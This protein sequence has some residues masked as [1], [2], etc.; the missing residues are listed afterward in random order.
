MAHF[1]T[2]ARPRK[3]PLQARSR[4]LVN[5]LMQATA[6]ILVRDGW[7]ALTTNRVANEAGVSVGSLYQYF[8]HKDALV[9]ALVESWAETLTAQ[10]VALGAELLDAS[11]EVGARRLVETVLDVTRADQ[12]LHRS[13]LLQLPRIG[14]LEAFERLNQR[15]AEMLAE[16]IALHRN[17]VD[18]DDPSLTAHV[19]VTSLDA[20]IDHA[21]LLRPE[22]LTSR[23]FALTLERL[24]LGLLGVPTGTPPTGR[25]K[26]RSRT[27]RSS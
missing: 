18:V 19:I 9:S 16:W 1:S 20:L 15:S 14:A 24:V 17:E 25:R 2:S 5:A 23:R 22:L 3:R 11:V 12:A 4:D 26:R 7:D 6:R 21:L 8:P 27:A 13:V 10:F